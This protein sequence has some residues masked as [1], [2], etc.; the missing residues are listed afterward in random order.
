MAVVDDPHSCAGLVDSVDLLNELVENIN[1]NVLCEIGHD[2]TNLVGVGRLAG[3]GRQSALDRK[4][5][6]NVTENAV[7]EDLT[8]TMRPLVILG[9]VL[10][11]AFEDLAN[12]VADIAMLLLPW[13]AG[14]ANGVE[15]LELGLEKNETLRP[16]CEAIRLH[17]LG[18][19]NNHTECETILMLDLRDLCGDV[20]LL[21][22]GWEI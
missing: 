8:S 4:V 2:S 19:G 20:L 9:N 3:K 12:L 15:R 10:Q 13:S 1:G 18:S 22:L 14:C 6:V 17:R 16:N 5:L 7:H 11:A 21:I